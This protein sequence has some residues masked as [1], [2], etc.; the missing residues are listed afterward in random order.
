MIKIEVF[1][2]GAVGAL[3]PEIL[4][5]YRLRNR[6]DRFKWSWF[7]LLVSLLFAGLGGVVATVLPATTAWSALYAGLSTP[8]LITKGTERLA[9]CLS[10]KVKSITTVHRHTTYFVSFIKAL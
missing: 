5:L 3:A 10:P 8:I 2:F 7:Y 1:A 4:R 9:E 6:P